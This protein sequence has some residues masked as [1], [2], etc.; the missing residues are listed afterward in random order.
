MKKMMN[1]NLYIHDVMVVNLAKVI[2][3][4]ITP[5]HFAIKFYTDNT[6]HALVLTLTSEADTLSEFRMITKQ[7][8]K[9][10]GS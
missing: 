9:C 1:N 5:K 6:D 2:A 3:I 8:R 10:N 4:T 7:W